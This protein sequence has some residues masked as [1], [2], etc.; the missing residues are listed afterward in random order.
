MIEPII[1]HLRENPLI[2]LMVMFVGIFYWGVSARRRARN[3]S[4]SED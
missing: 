1:Q 3:E 2:W 4:N